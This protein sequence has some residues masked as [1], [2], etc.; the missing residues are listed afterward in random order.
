MKNKKT[1]SLILLIN[2]L[3]SICCI[4]TV[5][6]VTTCKVSF[7]VNATTAE[8]SVSSKTVTYGETYGTLPTPTRIGYTFSG[9]YTGAA[10]GIKINANSKVTTADNHTLYAHWIAKKYT[11][12]FDCDGGTASASGVPLVEPI[13]S[14]VTYDS[15]YGN[16]ILSIAVGK[17]GYTFD[18]W[19]TAKI[20]GTK[21]TYRDKVTTAKNHTLYAHWIANKYTL[22]FDC[23][24]GT[25]SKYGVPLD[26]PVITTVSYDESYLNILSLAVVKTGYTF[27][28][29]YT[30]KVGGVKITA[31]DK[32]TVVEDYTLYAHW[33]ANKYTITLNTN[34]GICNTESIKVTYDNTYGT[35]PTPTKAGYTFDGWYTGATDGTKIS[36]SD[37]VTTASDH[38]LYAHW[39][40][41]KYLVAVD[42]NGG[43]CDTESITVTYNNTYGTLPTPTRVGYTF[44]GWYTGATGGTRISENSKVTIPSNHTLYA[45]WMANEYIV[46]F[47]INDGATQANVLEKT[48]AYDSVYGT[49]PT[50]T[51]VGYTLEGWYTG[52][53]DGT[54]ISESDKATIASNH[55]LYAH[56]IAN[57]YKVTLDA[58][59]G[60][61]DTE[62]ITVIYDGTYSDLPQAKSSDNLIFKGWFT[63]DNTLI[64]NDTK[65]TTAS[66]H[67]LYAKYGYIV[68]LNANGGI[69]GEY[70]IVLED[71]D[72]FNNLPTPVKNG[73]IF[74]GWYSNPMFTQQITSDTVYSDGNI[75][76]IY[77]RYF[78]KKAT[79]VKVK[80][81][82]YTSVE[83]SWDRQADVS[84]YM[85]YVKSGK[86]GYKLYKTVNNSN[87]TSILIS[88]LSIKKAYSFKVK[89]FIKIQSKEYISGF[90][91]SVIRQKTFLQKPK[92]S[93]KYSQNTRL[94]QVKWKKVK[95]AEG[96]MV[97][98]FK[99]GKYKLIKTTN[100]NAVVFNVI[101]GKQYKLKIC[102]YKKVLGKRCLSKPAYF[103]YK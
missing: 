55:T 102:A 103:T 27:D 21:V 67:T 24:G 2:V 73:Y 66:D 47:N 61:C 78:H 52:V 93:Y 10:N 39:K 16:S 86:Q 62:S 60:I 7:N 92:I 95:G 80:L 94:L 17:T 71:G 74:V 84:G 46:T 14:T 31:K 44:D 20:G 97:Y 49:L 50:P 12:S 33:K 29:W 57:E 40:E 99:N 19:Y 69:C 81:K 25:A 53:T 65:V 26:E 51:R 15:A 64:T 98:S 101:S 54:K 30:E 34:G 56:W 8:C 45:H 48:I 1:I 89:S 23:N 9:W 36:V 3:L 59:E 5:N 68:K 13:Q 41:G 43:T 85:V 11:V 88:K 77:A 38:T 32:V 70:E 42:A 6:A 37:K 63:S 75:T 82:S 58:G 18:G 91:D 100:N 76:S 83:L 22:T 28:G 96:Y 87:T 79:G 90:S 72:T 4:P 35:L